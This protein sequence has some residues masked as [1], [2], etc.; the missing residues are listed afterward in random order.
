MR[1]YGKADGGRGKKLF[2]ADM[3]GGEGRKKLLTG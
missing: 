2:H 1:K 3:G